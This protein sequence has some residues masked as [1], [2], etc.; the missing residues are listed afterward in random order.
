[1]RIYA[2][3]DGHTM[4]QYTWITLLHAARL[5]KLCELQSDALLLLSSIS[6]YVALPWVSCV[7]HLQNTNMSV[8]L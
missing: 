7:Y 3:L 6:L 1:M 5:P 2:A 4:L 8:A